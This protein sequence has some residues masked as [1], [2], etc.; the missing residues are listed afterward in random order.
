MT[1]D[2]AFCY[3]GVTSPVYYSFNLDVTTDLIDAFG[4]P[5]SSCISF[6]GSTTLQFQQQFDYATGN[7][8]GNIYNLI[9]VDNYPPVNYLWSDG[10]TTASVTD[11]GDSVYTVTV[12]DNLC[13]T[14]EIFNEVLPNPQLTPTID[15]FY[16][17]GN[18]YGDISLYVSDGSGG[19]YN[20]IWFD[21]STNP[22]VQGLNTGYYS[23]TV[24]DGRQCVDT[25]TFYVPQGTP[26]AINAVAAPAQCYGGQGT[27]TI[28]GS[29]GVPPYTNTGSFSEPPGNYNFTISDALGCQASTSV[30]V[31]SPP[32]L[33]VNAT[34]VSPVLC[35]GS[36]ATVNVTASGGTPPYF[37]DGTV[38]LPSGTNLV[39]VTDGAGCVGN[40]TVTVPP[41][42]YTQLVLGYSVTQPAC[43]GDSAT[44]TITA[45]GGAPPYTGTG[46]F[47]R[48]VGNWTFQVFDSVSCAAARVITVT[49]A[50]GIAISLDTV[51][52]TCSAGSITANASNGTGPYQYQW[53]TSPGFGDSSTIYVRDTG[54]YSVTVQDNNGCIAS[55]STFVGYDNPVNLDEINIVQYPSCDADD[56]IFALEN[57]APN[58][59]VTLATNVVWG[60]LYGTYSYNP[61]GGVSQL[62]NFNWLG[63][64][65]TDYDV[66]YNGLPTIYWI[67]EDQLIDPANFA[68]LDST[69]TQYCGPSQN[70]AIKVLFNNPPDII[71]IVY[72]SLGDYIYGEGVTLQNYP[73]MTYLWSNGAT[74]ASIDSLGGGNYSVTISDGDG[75]CNVTLQASLSYPPKPIVSSTVNSNICNAG[76]INITNVTSGGGS[77][78]NYNWSTGATGDAITNLSSGNY[79]VT[80]TGANDCPAIDSFAIGQQWLH[81]NEVIDSARC[82][83]DSAT[84]TLTASGGTL[85]YTG[86]GTFIAPPGEFIFTVTDN[87]GCY[88]HD[89]VEITQPT[90]LVVHDN[91]D[92]ILC[93]GGNATINVTASGGTSPYTGTGS[94]M[95]PAGTSTITV[96]D[97]NGCSATDTV[98]ITQPTAIIVS[99]TVHP[100][101]CNNDAE[102]IVTAS[103]GTGPY[104]GNGNIFRPTGNYN[105]TVTDANGCRASANAS[106]NQPPALSLRVNVTA[107]PCFGDS[108]TISIGALGGTQPYTGTGTF[109]RPAGNYIFDVTD[110]SG[111]IVADTLNIT[112][113]VAL[114]VTDNI[115]T[116]VNCYGESASVLVSATGGTPPYIGTGTL[117][118]PAG[119]DV[120]TVLD[121]HGCQSSAHV[122]IIQPTPLEIGVAVINGG[123]CSDSLQVAVSATGGTSPYTGVGNKTY[124]HNGNYTLTVTDVNGCNADSTL[125]VHLD[126]CTGIETMTENT[127][128]N[129]YPNPTADRFYIKF[130]TPLNTEADAR[131]FAIDGKTVLVKTLGT[132]ENLFEVNCNYLASGSYILRTLLNNRDYYFKIVITR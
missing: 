97:A 43:N 98:H 61:L 31:T 110:S 62:N 27:V 44:I 63:Y 114:S 40:T 58:G 82:F 1:V 108:S 75:Q 13:T 70:G 19:P 88:N 16:C 37:N 29:A 26:V 5:P 11:L 115:T 126:T 132:G 25:A 112:Q 86:T 45:S 130:E 106:V 56:G 28:S 50:Q 111:C 121:A 47:H 87:G 117:S 107:V 21:G 38:Y 60:T 90:K 84:I 55:A 73:T 54:T 33:V 95:R 10:E 93:N 92:P 23:V 122:T 35:Y 72:D 15:S 41:G 104:T 127:G 32:A 77:P 39:Q 100:I 128:I 109:T 74:T 67:T 113:P 81:V 22:D 119:N 79:K 125:A 8:S 34:I 131:L 52:I 14:V 101:P 42:P 4:S 20:Y 7:N 78:Y 3:N 48:S 76:S 12:T 17:A 30:V 53:S 46:V 49:P 83:G 69:N 68:Y 85:P 65:A 103:G 123:H 89:T 51:G 66:C 120:I 71:V 124:S 129:V 80:V 9:T 116:P 59:Q 6:D 24:T 18:S 91:I 64:W 36:D 102:I 118:E 105:L 96:S 94:L 99:D 57:V 2:S